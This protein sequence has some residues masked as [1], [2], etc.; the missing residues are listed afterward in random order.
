MV[1][2][3]SG[4]SDSKNLPA[5][6]ETQVDPWVGKIPSGKETAAHSSVLAWRIMVLVPCKCMHVQSCLT[7]H[8][9]V[10]CSPPGSSVHG[11]FRA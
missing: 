5:M 11:I 4:G 8:D 7:L 10:D 9:S 6:Q 2:G 1:L 3:F